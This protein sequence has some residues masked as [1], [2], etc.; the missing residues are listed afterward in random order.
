MAQGLKRVTTNAT[1]SIP[2]IINEIF[3]IFFAL[4]SRKAAA[5]SVSTGN[6]CSIRRKTGN[7]SVLMETKYF[8]TRLPGALC[9]Q[10]QGRNPLCPGYSVKPKKDIKE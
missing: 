10:K 5:L 3:Y 9:T 6:A 1:G 2:T 7:G 8:N 4:V